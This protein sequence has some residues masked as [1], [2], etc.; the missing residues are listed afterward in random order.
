MLHY[1]IVPCTLKKNPASHYSST[2]LHLNKTELLASI[3]KVELFSIN[4]KWNDDIV[5]QLDGKKEGGSL[6]E[7]DVGTW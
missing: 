1:Q 3:D 4:L 2:N 6:Q 7:C 5:E